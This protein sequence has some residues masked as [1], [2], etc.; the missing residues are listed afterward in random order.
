MNWTKFQPAPIVGVDEVGRGC[1]AGP[2]VAAAVVFSKPSRRRLY[3]DSKTVSEARR[4]ELSLRIQSEH[5]WCIGFATVEEID[6]LNIF[7]ASLLA[8][9]RAVEG[10][11]LTGGHLLVDGK[12]TIPGLLQYEQTALIKGDSRSELISAAS[13]V[14]KVARDRWM[15]D[16]AGKFPGYGF[17]VHKGYGTAQHRDALARLGPCEFHRRSFAGIGD[18]VTA[19]LDAV[20]VN[21]QDAAREFGMEDAPS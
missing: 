4:E 18:M 15:K 11:G 12:F 16:L 20:R 1:L 21:G 14:A 7:H 6:Q 13:L 10:L 3:F 8:M 19:A 9:R 2:V 5:Q 17:E